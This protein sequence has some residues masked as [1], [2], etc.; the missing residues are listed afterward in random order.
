IRPRLEALDLEIVQVPDAYQDDVPHDDVPD[1]E[2]D[3]LAHDRRWIEA[4]DV[5]LVL[6]ASWQEH[7]FSRVGMRHPQARF[8]ERLSDGR[9]GFRLAARF[10]TSFLTQPLY[11]WGDPMLRG[12]WEAGIVGYK[13]FVRDDALA[14][15]AP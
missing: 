7:Q 6:L 12:H 11:V 14:R 1:T 5:Q 4:N 10:E 15:V 2:A 8:A 3:W 9:L 13:V